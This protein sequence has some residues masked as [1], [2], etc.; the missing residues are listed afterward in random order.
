MKKAVPLQPLMYVGIGLTGLLTTNSN[1]HFC[2][3]MHY[4]QVIPRTILVNDSVSG[5]LTGFNFTAPVYGVDIFENTKAVDLF[6]SLGF[7][8]GRLRVYGNSLVKQKNA[9]FS[10]KVSLTP[11]FKLGRLMLQMNFD[12]ELDVSKKAWRK[13]AVAGTPQYYLPN[14]S[15]TGLSAYLMLGFT[16][17]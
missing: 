11:R 10:P 5:N 1:Y 9:Y 3:H 8:T 6:F 2:G 7:N 4:T 13:I 14:T 17:D 16:L 15:L 12:Y